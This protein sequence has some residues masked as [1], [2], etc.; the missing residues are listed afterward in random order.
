MHKCKCKISQSE[1]P[2][3]DSH[4]SSSDARSQT[5]ESF[6]GMVGSSLK[7][8]YNPVLFKEKGQQMQNVNI[9]EIL[10]CQGES[11]RIISH[12]GECFGEKKLSRHIRHSLHCC[13][14]NK[15]LYNKTEG[16]SSNI[17]CR[18]HM[19]SRPFKVF[20]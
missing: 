9:T 12:L 6:G 5:Q 7:C 17:S 18:I 14:E 15:L 20:D 19:H 3:D 2:L 4:E 13:K 16:Y 1:G 11:S 8:I 10:G